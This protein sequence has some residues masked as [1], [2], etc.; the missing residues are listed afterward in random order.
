MKSLYTA[1]EGD[2][3]VLE[4][5]LNLV[6]DPRL[7]YIFKNRSYLK[8]VLIISFDSKFIYI[9]SSKKVDDLATSENESGGYFKYKIS[10]N[11]NLN[12]SD[13]LGWRADVWPRSLIELFPKKLINDSK[14][15]IICGSLLGDFAKAQSTLKSAENNPY[16]TKESYIATIIHEFGH[17]YFRQHKNWWF[18]N[19]DYN[20]TLLREA[21][22]L[23]KNKKNKVRVHVDITLPYFFSEI[24]AFCCEYEASKIFFPLHRKNLD[25]YAIEI[26]GK[27]IEYEKKVDLNV[28]NSILS[29]Q[30]S[31]ETA[32]VLGKI[33][34]EKFPRTWPDKIL[35][36][37]QI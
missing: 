25:K 36:K 9:W 30:F 4:Q 21:L 24:F 2:F 19:K 14:N 15:S 7:K 12:K 23:Y 28:E 37:P 17:I 34:L 31:H 6:F 32:L 13:R 10:H 27:S 5:A 16:T 3:E 8:K 22:Q 29:D 11:V 26:I 33:L 1:T 20:L 18:S 35:G